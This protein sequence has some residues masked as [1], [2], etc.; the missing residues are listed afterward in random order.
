MQRLLRTIGEFIGRRPI[1]VAVTSTLAFLGLGTGWYKIS[2]GG[3]MTEKDMDELWSLRGG[4]V[5]R[6]VMTV[7]RMQ[8][9]DWKVT[10]H[11]TMFLGKGPW[12]GADMFTPEIFSAMEPLYS[13]FF[14]LKVTTSSGREYSTWDLCA[15]GAM[16]D[17]PGSP[18][19]CDAWEASNRTDANLQ[20]AC[21]PS[22]YLPCLVS[23]PQQCFSEHVAQLPESYKVLDPVS[24]QVLPPAF[25]PRPFATRPSYRNLTAAE[26]KA[27]ASKMRATGARGCEWFTGLTV[28]N[29][30]KWGGRVQ[31]NAEKTLITK[32]PALMWT[33]FYDA[34]PR[35]SFRMSMSKPDHA[36]DKAEI[37]EATQLHERAWQSEVIAFAETLENVEVLNVGPSLE[38]EL[39]EENN[40]MR[41]S[42]VIIGGTLMCLFIAASL[43]SF[44]DPL[45]SRVNLGQH[46]LSVV[47]LATA[48][49]SGLILLLGFEFNAAMISA[50]PF[51]ALGLG[52]DDMFVLIRYFSD[53]GVDYI[54]SRSYP[55]IIGEV[56]ARG[57]AGATLTSVCNIAAFGCGAMLPVP[58]MSDFCIGAAIISL[59]NY[60]AMLTLF[61]PL[62]VLE[63]RRV[64]RREPELHPLTFLCHRR[65]LRQE[66]GVGAGGAPPTERGAG[67][68]R[69]TAALSQ[70]FAGLGERGV[71]GLKDWYGPLLT[72]LPV[73]AAVFVLACGFGAVSCWSVSANKTIGFNVA[74]VAV[75]GTHAQRALEV[76]FEKFQTFPAQVCFYELDV[77][78]HQREMLEL[79]DAVTRSGHAMPF[80]LPPFLTM[81]SFYVGPMSQTVVPGAPNTTYADRGWALDNS[82]T[83]P[84]WAP[85]GTVTSNASA[86]YSAYHTWS[87]M[88][89]DNPADAFLPGGSAF[90]EADL[91]FT[92]E[93]KLVD[94]PGSNLR[95]SFFMFYQTG[96]DTQQDYVTAIQEVRQAFADSPL[97]KEQA[98]PWGA[99]FT[100]WSVFLELESVL[101]RA[102]I[103]DVVV[104]FFVTLLLL[105]SMTAALASTFSCVL[106]IIQVYGASVLFARF[107][108][109]VAAG[110]LASAGISIEF[111]SHL[112]ASFDT[113]TGTLPERL[114]TAMAHTTPPLVQGAISTLLS[115]LPMAFSPLLFVVK[116]FFA[117]FAL[118]CLFGLV[119]G[120]LFL[121]AL[122]ALLSPF[123]SMLAGITAC[124][125]TGPVAEDAPTA[126]KEQGDLP[127][128][129]G[130]A[131]TTGK[132]SSSV[133]G[134]GCVSV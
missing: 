74:E 31:W 121:P 133:D 47:G 23:S 40:K 91:V 120:M 125:R 21:H 94:G 113:V 112:V 65:A 46:G 41:W 58:A 63:A 73:R 105:R 9:E 13:R 18:P 36:A 1:L 56:L 37:K 33:L 134:K 96:L 39:I 80:D 128:L 8:N 60:V 12:E 117:L 119:T 88:P 64:K 95:Y 42:L 11:V 110:L 44:Q 19:A 66:Q 7:K 126:P 97:T 6:E 57:G 123:S 108:V 43:V 69:G 49:S 109:F 89:L 55:E 90:I 104:I 67:P 111:T 5:E 131:G 50:L 35:I 71:L 52:V 132:Q 27:E 77:P 4:D 54:T 124:C 85:L 83:H 82:W 130:A 122:L 48:A 102:F 25:L 3:V 107:N 22:P 84:L 15:R 29:A 78:G 70:W 118:V 51:M 2:R 24:D 101:L 68:R 59:L 106:I 93:F 99:T 75:S 61:L 10:A 17:Y 86:F 76:L 34:A 103:I 98:F 81:F 53:L 79:Y 20:A 127:A 14:N 116:Y 45:T 28:F 30:E 38:D 92:N 115:L 26:M 87:T 72:R 129:L 16:P 62:M 32:V 100:F 114:G